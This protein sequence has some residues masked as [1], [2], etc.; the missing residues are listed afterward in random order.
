M[1]KFEELKVCYDD[2]EHQVRNSQLLQELIRK[3][4]EN[5]KIILDEDGVTGGM[6][7]VKYFED[8]SVEVIEG[9]AINVASMFAGKKPCIMNFADFKLPGGWVTKGGSAQEESICRSTTLNFILTSDKCMNGYYLPNKEKLKHWEFPQFYDDSMIFTPDV[10]VIKD[11]DRV[12]K[13]LDYSKC[14]FIDVINCVAP[15]LYR[16]YPDQEDLMRIYTKRLHKFFEIAK[17]E[18]EE[19]LILGAW[20]CGA[21]RNNPDPISQVFK[22]LI[23]EYRN[24]FKKIIFAIPSSG[25]N[26]NLREF[27]EKMGVFVDV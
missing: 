17:S 10:F 26:R 21:F 14:Y 6:P 4:I 20:G 19:I 7:E 2:T 9:T 11:G 16:F 23:K 22:N 3:S 5:C 13:N 15:N 1:G 27:R 25:N 12:P 24:E 8:C 18:G